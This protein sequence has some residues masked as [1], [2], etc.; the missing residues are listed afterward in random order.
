[1]KNFLLNG[2]KKLGN[3][4]RW[5][6]GKIPFGGLKTMFTEKGKRKWA[7]A[8]LVLILFLF[9]LMGWF[10]SREPAGFDV[11]DNSARLSGSQ[12][13]EVVIGVT[14]TAALIRTA[15][16][17]LDK[18]G[19]Y[20]SNDI[21]PPFVFLD[22]M[23]NWEYGALVQVR[24]LAHA[25][26][27]DI[28][29]TRSQSAENPYLAEASPLFNTNNNKW[30]F[31]R[32]E[33]QYREGIAAL[34]LYLEGLSK[35]NDPNTQF[36]A[37]AD[38]LSEWLSIVEKRLGG[39]SQKLSASVGQARENTDLAGDDAATQSTATRNIVAVKTPWLEIDDV[40]YEARGAT[41][42]LLQFLL[43]VEV[44]FEAVLEKKN[45]KALVRQIIRELIGTQRKVWSPMILNGSGFGFT[46]NHSLVMAAYIS[47]AN[48][49]I[50]ELRDLLSQG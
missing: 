9:F 16:T 12:E 24:D 10:V 36:F 43:A 11:R 32:T 8:A 50:I 44:D 22:N 47:R 27:N 21:M 1:M 40:F 38:N 23:P 17:L 46:A 26:R 48:A 7:L 20:I 18:P 41:W 28:S 14:T 42:A 34:E 4:L 19:G 37:R 2:L 15:R 30:I 33:T 45:A 39:L 29:R 25:L 35:K 31:P 13:G 5:L 6:F 49:A 3:G